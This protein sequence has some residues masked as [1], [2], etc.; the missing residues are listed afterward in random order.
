MFNNYIIDSWQKGVLYLVTVAII[1]FLMFLGKKKLKFGLRVLLGMTLGLAVGFIFGPISTTINNAPGSVV[2]TIRPIGQLYLKLIQMVV[3]PLVFT[4]VIKSF[5]SLE[6]TSALK[7]IGV[8]SLFWLLVTT[9]VAAAIG[10]GFASMV[11]LGSNFNPEGTYVKEI[12]P[13]E[14]VILN[15]FPNNIFTAFSGSVILPVITV[16]L[17]ISIAVIVENKRHPE[18]TKPFVDFNNSLNTIMTRVTKFVISM[19]PYAVFSFMAYAVARSNYETLSELALYIGIMYGAM[20]FHFLFVQMLLIRVMGINP[21]KWVQKFSPAMFVAFT[22]QSSYGTLPVT[23]ES[24]TKRVGV[25]DKIANFVGPLSANIGMNACGGIFPAVV[26]VITANA[27]GINLGVA[28][29]ILLL[30]VTTISAIGIAGVP[31]IAT[32]AAAVVLSSLGL[33][34]DGIALIVAVDPL[35]DMGRTMINVIGAGVAATMVAKREKELNLDVLNA[36]EPVALTE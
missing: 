2:A 1:A 3:V 25:S 4:A 14:T 17:F 29:F 30:I 13:I 16:A 18:R 23:I 8:K 27:Y 21:I 5:T 32:I 20:L 36:K 6:S 12:T 11:N 10:F 35:I 22:T 33:P 26:A 19:T 31:G 7:R 28:D 34:I 9:T 15:F 24:L